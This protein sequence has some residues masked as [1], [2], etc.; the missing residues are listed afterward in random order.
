MNTQA[1]E[2]N[3]LEPEVKELVEQVLHLIWTAQNTIAGSPAGVY[4]KLLE[5]K[6]Y[7]ELS[8]AL[9]LANYKCEDILRS[10]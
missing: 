9:S 8:G 5:S 10:R 1:K 3:K 4:E 2:E 6:H 7:S